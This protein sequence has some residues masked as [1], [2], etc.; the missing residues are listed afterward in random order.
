MSKY[1][2]I[3]KLSILIP[4]T[5]ARAQN[6]MIELFTILEK[7]VNKLANPKDVELLVLL[8]NKRR[9]IGYKRES[10][11]HIA[12][13]NFVAFMDDDDI[14]HDFYIEEAIKAIDC[15]PGVDVIT[16][17]EYVYIN[18]SP[19]YELTFELGYERNDAVQ[20]PNAKRPP[21]HC[22]FWNRKLAQ[23]FHF[24]DL[25]YGEDWAWAEQINKVAKTSHHIDKFMRTYVYN[26]QVTEA[27]S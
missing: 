8:D 23:K 5:P 15:S 6:K 3:P 16:F 21:W 17:K 25:M 24:P 11:L 27:I 14:V 20:I 4:S 26:D 7:Q 9:S 2:P 19:R 18:N 10:L 22:C 1:S 12:R 13:G